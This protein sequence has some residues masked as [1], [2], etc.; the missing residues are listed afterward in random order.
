MWLIRG[1]LHQYSTP[2]GLVINQISNFS[3][4]MHRILILHS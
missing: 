1:S 2:L 3:S 4:D